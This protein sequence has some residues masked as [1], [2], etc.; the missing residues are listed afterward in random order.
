MVKAH[1]FAPL[2]VWP[3]IKF[4]VSTNKYYRECLGVVEG[5]QQI[6]ISSS[7]DI[8]LSQNHMKKND[9]P[10]YYVNPLTAENWAVEYMY[11]CGKPQFSALQTGRYPPSPAYLETIIPVWH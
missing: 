2:Y 6:K 11:H 7:R 10:V 1:L 8:L 9:K 4:W 3:S 5:Y